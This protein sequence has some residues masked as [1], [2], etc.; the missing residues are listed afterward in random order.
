MTDTRW[1]YTQPNPVVMTKIAAAELE[2]A[3]NPKPKY[4][5]F[6]TKEYR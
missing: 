1:I 4:T 2:A 6:S 5:P 3:L